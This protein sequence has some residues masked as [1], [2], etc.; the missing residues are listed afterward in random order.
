MESLQQSCGAGVSR[1]TLGIGLTTLLLR[2]AW[3]KFAA[4]SG[5]RAF[6]LSLRELVLAEAIG[7]WGQQ[8]H[9]QRYSGQHLEFKEQ[10]LDAHST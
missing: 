8:E 6:A 2:L 3:L 10:T 1:F 9:P 7:L 4:G 5:Q